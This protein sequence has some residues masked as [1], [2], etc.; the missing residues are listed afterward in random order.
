MPGPVA[1]QDPE[2]RADPLLR[3]LMIHHDLLVEAPPERPTAAHRAIGPGAAVTGLLDAALDRD[4]AVPTVRTL[5]RVGPGGESALRRHGARIGA[6]AGDVVTARIALDALPALLAEKGLR[7]VETASTLSPLGFHPTAPRPTARAGATT[8]LASD[9]AAAD[10]GFEALRRRAGQGWEGLAGRGVIVG[11]YDSGL[12]LEHPDFRAPSGATRVLFAWDQTVAGSGPGVVGEHH[13]DYGVECAGPAI[14]SGACPMVDRSG[15][16]TH[17]AGTAAGNGSATGRTLPAFRYPGGAPAAEL[18]IVKGGDTEFTADR[19]VEGVAYIFARAAALG[20]P[21]VVN[22]SLSSQAGPHDGTTLLERALDALSGPGRIVVSGAGNAGDHRNTLP[23]VRNGPF[24]A[25][26]RAGGAAHGLR[27]PPYQPAPGPAN[28]A[29]LMEIWYDGADSVAITVRSPRGDAVTAATGDTVFFAT[30]GGAV[31]IVNA[32]DGPSPLNGDHS[33]LI[34]ILDADADMPPDTGRWA[35]EVAPVAV[36][37]TG[38][39]HLWLV[40]SSFAAETVVALEGGTTNRYLV[41]VPASADR[42]L[43]AG[44]HVTRHGWQGVEGEEAF[45]FREQLGDIAYFSSPGPR[46]DGV[47]KPD[48]T[49]PG[50]VVIS[51]LSKDASLWDGVPWLVEADSVHVGLLGTSVSAP[52]VVAAVAILLQIE[53]GL[54]PEE[55][56]DLLRQ[57]AVVDRFVPAAVPHPIWGAGKLDAAAAVTR[58]R[59]DG[60]AGA[61]RPVTLSANPIRSDALVVGYAMRPR[62]IA[63]YTLA[64]ERVRTFRDDELG[65]VTAVWPLDTDAGGAVANGAYVLVVELPDRRVVQKLFVARP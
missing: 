48:V 59:P 36:H 31:I 24:H 11:V 20:R 50:K 53:P 28:D 61:A 6:R 23:L 10:A 15:H 38:D 57:S 62:S 49:A 64:A 25:Q 44:A 2:Q 27:V 54:T 21:A 3:L 32:L 37:A 22:V 12:D 65:V 18:I 14:E 41:G 58:L 5:V 1:G 45:P 33:A 8:G 63:I 47:Q 42:V 9:S 29:A 4:A 40:G 30:P 56:R 46:R 35:I 43:A 60:L 16:G 17:V 13:F 52:Q 55:A 34:A 39:Y 51:S 19:L 7:A 26:G